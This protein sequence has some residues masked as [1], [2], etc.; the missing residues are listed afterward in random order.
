MM[1][2]IALQKLLWYARKGWPI[3]PVFWLEDGRCGCGVAGCQAPGKHP[4]TSNGFYDA[5]TDADRILEWYSHYPKA[6]WAM[7]TG[8]ESGLVVMDIDKRNGGIETWD[9]LR[10]DYP[11]PIETVLVKTRNDGRHYWFRLPEGMNYKSR[12]AL[13]VGIDFKADGGYVLLPPS[14]GYEFLINPD[15]EL[16]DLPFWVSERL[17]QLSL[18]KKR[19]E[20]VKVGAIPAGSRHL[21]LVEKAARLKNDGFDDTA[22]KAA[23]MSLRDNQMDEGDHPVTDEEVENVL[24]W[25]KEKDRRFI[26]SDLGNAERFI[27]LNQD[28]IRFC[29]QWDTWLYWDDRHWK[30]DEDG[31]AKRFAHA[32]IRTIYTEVAAEEDEDRRRN[33]AKFAIASE[34]SYRVGAMLES[35]KPYLPIRPDEMDQHPTLLC[36]CNGIIDLFTGELLPHNPDMKL[37]KLVDIEY[38]PNAKCPRWEE[39]IKLVTGGDEDLASYLQLAV[40]YSLTGLVDEHNLFVVWGLGKNGKTTFF[41]ALQMLFGDYAKKTD[42][43]AFLANFRTGGGMASPS[44]AGLKGVRLAWAT[45]VTGGDI[46]TARFLF[47]NPFEF[48]PTHKLWLMGNYKPKIRGTD[49]GIRRRIRIIPFLTTITHPRPQSEVLAEFQAELSGILAWAVTGAIMWHNGGLGIPPAVK[50]ATDEYISES[51]LVGQFLDARCE[52][53]PDYSIKRTTLYLEWKSFCESEGEEEATKHGKRWLTTQLQNR[54][55]EIGGKA[56]E[57]YIGIRVIIS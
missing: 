10:T 30:V 35:A 52:M 39:F 12:Q 8:P 26:S 57:S 2:E 18:K 40:G 23:L 11:E 48:K 36:V 49:E 50:K 53:K 27:S 28:K 32:T 17:R 47:G 15:T 13:W 31:A 44:I 55:I 3:F 29:P 9:L 37:T 34:A 22:I 21:T 25:V 56:N 5:I 51:D 6:G 38:D 46:I 4:I 54:G 16:Q 41:L 24:T 42:I 19:P 7:R 33:L 45:E 43:E 14:S 1:A 20:A